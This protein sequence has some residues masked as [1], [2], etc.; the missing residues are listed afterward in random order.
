MASGNL[1]CPI[2]FA[3]QK[4]PALRELIES[5]FQVEPLPDQ[6]QACVLSTDALVPKVPCT[7]ALVPKVPYS[8]TQKYR[9]EKCCLL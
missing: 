2:I 3:M 7:D 1:T 9:C 4:N 8:V 6:F 5:E